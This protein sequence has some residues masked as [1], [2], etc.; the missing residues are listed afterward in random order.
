MERQR[1]EESLARKA[2]EALRKNCDLNTTPTTKGVDSDLKDIRMV[3]L[4]PSKSADD[5]LRTIKP[6]S[7][8]RMD[9]D[10]ETFAS[11]NPDILLSTSFIVGHLAKSLRT[12]HVFRALIVMVRVVIGAHYA[13]NE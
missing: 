7:P 1:R 2:V 13:S 3:P 8:D 11:Q 12:S 5:P 9:V 10:K 6:A 4:A